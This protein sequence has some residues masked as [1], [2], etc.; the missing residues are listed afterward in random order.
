MDVSAL[1]H[2]LKTALASCRKIT[3]LR[4]S[5]DEN[6]RALAMLDEGQLSDLS[7]LGLQVWRAE[8]RAQ[9]HASKNSTQRE[10]QP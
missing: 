3:G 10:T 4:A 5:A 9:W 1:R 6:R 8:R 2:V 7:E